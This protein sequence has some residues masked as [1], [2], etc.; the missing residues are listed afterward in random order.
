MTFRDIQHHLAATVTTE[1]SHATISNITEG[2]ADEV[3]QLQTRPLEAFCPVIFLDSIAVRFREQHRVQNRAA[4]IAV[5]VDCDG[6]KHVLGIWVQAHEGA[7]FVDGVCA[8]LAN[9]GIR[10]VLIVACDGLTSFREAVK[11]VWPSALVQ[12]C[13]PS[14]PRFEGVSD[15]LCK[16]NREER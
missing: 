13:G 4:H 11:A 5:G 7:N 1:P 15:G 8:E 12:T 10:E 6:L 9:R 14:G 3:T 16:P 2:V